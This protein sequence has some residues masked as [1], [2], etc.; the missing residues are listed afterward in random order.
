MKFHFPKFSFNVLFVFILLA[1]LLGSATPAQAAQRDA[2]LPVERLLKADGRLDLSTGYSGELDITNFDVSLDPA[3][4]PT[5]KP[6]ASPNVWN[7]LGSGLNNGVRAVAVSG[8]DVYVGGIFTDA[9]G[10]ANADYI[11][12]F[13]GGVWSALGAT[14]LNSSVSA[15]AV[16]GADVYAG[17]DFTDAGGDV[18]ADYIAKFS[19]G[20]W[21]ALGGTPLNN[22][23]Y[24]IAVSGADVYAGGGFL[25]AG[26]DANADFIAKF[27]GGVW[28]AW[29]RR[30]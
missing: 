24:A 21:S 18:N 16:S 6:L 4:G 29:A 10:D 14:P 7:A 26:G 23:V 11:A 22:T 15:I 25:N 13:S 5:F 8:T 17:G 19:G 28:S 3:L 1:S 20:A 12:K 27:S 30:R 9:G 2:T